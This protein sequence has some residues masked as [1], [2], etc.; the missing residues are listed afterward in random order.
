MATATAL[1]ALFETGDTLTEASFATLI[2][3]MHPDVVT[4]G[5]FT[6]STIADGSTTKQAL[7]SLE[8]AFEAFESDG[9]DGA[10][11]Y[12]IAV[13]NGFVGNEAAWLASLVGADGKDGTDGASAYAIA[14]A[15]GFVGNEAAWLAS[16]V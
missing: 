11:A 13:A 3:S 4:L 16:L 6:G 1:K 8:T 2:D 7:Q 14:V 12:A 15:N 5:T 10:S 9:E